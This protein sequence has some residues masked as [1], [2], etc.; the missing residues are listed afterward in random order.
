M[1]CRA[2]KPRGYDFIVDVDD[3][4]FKKYKVVEAAKPLR[5]DRDK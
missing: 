2:D 3:K 1:S 5:T 4:D